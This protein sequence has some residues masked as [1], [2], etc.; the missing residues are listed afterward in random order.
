MSVSH[1]FP[2]GMNVMMF[3]TKERWG[4]EKI[5][6]LMSSFFSVKLLKL[7]PAREKEESGIVCFMECGEDKI[8]S[9]GKWGREPM[10][11]VIAAW[12]RAFSSVCHGSVSHTSPPCLKS[13][14]K[15]RKHCQLSF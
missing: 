15:A 13:V 2:G 5:P 3:V 4:L 8:S 11:Q 7:S 9:V 12:C 10:L 14:E 1:L 6:S